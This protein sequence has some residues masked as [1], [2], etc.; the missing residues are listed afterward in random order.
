MEVEKACEIRCDKGLDFQTV[1]MT[2]TERPLNSINEI[3]RSFVKKAWS[4]RFSFLSYMNAQSFSETKS[5]F[6]I[7]FNPL[8]QYLCNLEFH[9]CD[10]DDSIESI[11]KNTRYISATILIYSPS[12]SL[13]TNLGRS[14]WMAVR[15]TILSVKL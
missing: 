14:R 3:G 12:R 9:E 2:H 10:F 8:C 4:V 7:V 5:N 15:R 6:W 1:R 11:S 13:Q